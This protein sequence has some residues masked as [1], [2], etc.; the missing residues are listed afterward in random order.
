VG[1]NCWRFVALR[2]RLWAVSSARGTETLIKTCFLSVFPRL[3]AIWAQFDDFSRGGQISGDGMRTQFFKRLKMTDGEQSIL[4]AL[5]A[6]A[7]FGACVAFS[8]VS[9]L[10]GGREIIRPLTGYDLWSIFAGASGSAIG[11]YLARSWFGHPG[12]HGIGQAAVGVLWVSFLGSIIGG[13]LALPFYGT[14]FGP[15][16]VIV[17]MFGA[18]LLALFWVCTLLG[19]HVLVGKWRRERDTI[20][21]DAYGDLSI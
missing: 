20:F 10:G 12:L 6:V 4:F 18:P 9:Q 11:L 19:A 13:T 7:V 21:V 2:A 3:A 1:I 8:V 5:F 14:M 15:F 16:S 17:T